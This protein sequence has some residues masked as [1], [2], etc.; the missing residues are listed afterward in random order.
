[1][2]ASDLRELGVVDRVVAELPDA[3]DEPEAF[4][5]RLGVVVEEEL[6]LPMFSLH[7]D[8]RASFERF[9]EAIMRRRLNGPKKRLPAFNRYRWKPAPKLRKK[10]RSQPPRR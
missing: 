6:G 5:R 1:V 2:R 7:S 4:C 3:A 8:G 9:A 10:Q